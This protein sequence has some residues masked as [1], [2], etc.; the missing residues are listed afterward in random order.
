MTDEVIKFWA[1]TPRLIYATNTDPA[2]VEN[3]IDIDERLTLDR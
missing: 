1:G 2:M 3:P